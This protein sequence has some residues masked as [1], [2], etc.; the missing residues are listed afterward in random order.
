MRQNRRSRWPRI[1]GH[2]EPEYP[3]LGLAKG[4]TQATIARQL[5]YSSC[6]ISRE[7]A[8]YSVEVIGYRAY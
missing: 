1:T 3:S 6:S 5:G 4:L 2:V 7:I 8:R